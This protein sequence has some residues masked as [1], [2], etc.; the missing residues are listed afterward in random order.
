[1]PKLG[2]FITS[3]NFSKEDFDDTQDPF[4][5][6]EYPP[7]VVNRCL[8]YFIDT[9]MLVNEMNQKPLLEPKIQFQYYLNAVR[10]KKRFA[11]WIKPEKI[12]DIDVVKETYNYNNERARE[13]LDLLTSEQIEL[14]RKKLVKGGRKKNGM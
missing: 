2:D 12:A 4:F 13:V 11:K 10:K 8:S 7:F 6:K 3:I 1:M 9:I 5:W 14:L